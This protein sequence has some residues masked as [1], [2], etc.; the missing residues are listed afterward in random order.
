MA[1]NICTPLPEMLNCKAAANLGCWNKAFVLYVMEMTNGEPCQNSRLN[2]VLLRAARCH[3][4][5]AEF[6]A[7]FE[8]AEK[9]VKKA[10]KRL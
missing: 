6:H 8:S 7:D 2:S 3:C 9:V 5:V 1:C 4:Q 10:P